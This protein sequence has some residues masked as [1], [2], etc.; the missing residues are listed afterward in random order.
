MRGREG[1]ERKRERWEEE[2]ER[3]EEERERWE[4]ERE[5][6]EEERDMR[7]RERDERKRGRWEE[8]R[9]MRGRERD[10]RK[11]E[12]WE[13]EREMRGRERDERKRERWEEE[14]E[15]RGR[16]RDERKRER[17][18]EEGEMREGERELESSYSA[19]N[20][21]F[22]KHIIAVLLTEIKATDFSRSLFRLVQEKYEAHFFVRSLTSVNVLR[23]IWVVVHTVYSDTISRLHVECF[24]QRNYL[25]V[26]KIIV[27]IAGYSFPLFVRFAKCRKDGTIFNSKI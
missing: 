20:W 25:L 14:G 8:E 3:W 9:E 26:I 17:W 11:R 5:R 22:I 21:K 6:W 2:R 13:E 19:V 27:R 4:E 18:E 16:G 10:E 23:A 15:M 12:R 24:S 1:D 7:G